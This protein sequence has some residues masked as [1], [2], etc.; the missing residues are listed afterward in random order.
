M[1]VA[2]RFLILVVAA[3]TLWPA[4]QSSAQSAIAKLID[5]VPA[6]LVV[7]DLTE[8]QPAA[9]KRVRGQL[10]SWQ[11]SQV[12][13]VLYLPTDFEDSRRF[14]VIVEFAGNG[15]YR[16]SLGDVSTGRPEG[17]NLGFGLSGGKGF[18]WIC[19]PY[20]S[21]D[22]TRNVTRWWGDA[23]EYD[24]T[25]TIDYCK[26]AVEWVCREYAG[27][28]NRVVLAGFSRGALAC[29]YIGLHDESIAKLWCGFVAYSH[30]D[31]VRRWPYPASDTESAV[32]R[33]RRLGKRPQLI[34][35]EQTGPARGLS[36]TREWLTSTGVEGNF[37]FLETGFRNHNDAWVLRPSEARDRARRWL[38]QFR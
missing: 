26:Q 37:T 13:H 28:P 36:A 15:D 6:D 30:Y 9:G 34:C 17:S 18:L 33:L 3:A 35:H 10:P 14:P 25:P 20:L 12:Y 5:D 21:S 22:G 8:G 19:V 27:D 38:R 31:G 7:P 2:P 1:T 24:V 32:A 4:G 23:P 29:N 16:S 11:G